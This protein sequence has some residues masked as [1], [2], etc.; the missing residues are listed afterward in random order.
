MYEAMLMEAENEDEG[1]PWR[2][3]EVQGAYHNQT[4]TLARLPD[5]LLVKTML[6]LDLDDILRLR[7]TSRDFMR[8]FSEVPE[9]RSYQVEDKLHPKRSAARVW[10]TPISSFPN[11]AATLFG[12]KLCRSCS[13]KRQGDYFGYRL[14]ESMPWFYCSGCKSRHRAMHFS[15]LQRQHKTDSDRICIGRECRLVICSHL[16]FSWDQVSV[17]ARSQKEP[18][19]FICN[20]RSHCKDTRCVSKRCR[21]DARPKVTLSCDS[22]GNICLKITRSWHLSFISPAAATKMKA[23]SFA[24]EIF[25]SQ[26]AENVLVEDLI[27]SHR[28]K[29]ALPMKAF[30][31]NICSCLDWETEDLEKIR[32]P[33]ARDFKWALT[34]NSYRPWRE[35]CQMPDGY[36]GGRYNCFGNRCLGMRHGFTLDFAGKTASIDF[37]RCMG[38]DTKLILEEVMTC[39][40]TSPCDPGWADLVDV[41]SCFLG[42][43]EE[44]RGI[45][46]CGGVCAVRALR[47]NNHSLKDVEF[48]QS[49]SIS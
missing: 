36:L 5:K 6:L 47:W 12:G 16:S 44:M 30:D 14:V 46:W 23:G 13:A 22:E 29:A 4:T 45:S 48:R 42:L 3:N 38:D 37:L 26:L 43:D 35:H 33:L 41:N 32:R 18:I 21:K 20:D 25:K 1:E 11:Q 34:P 2:M 8:L 39:S 28:F 9:F 24:D 49:K 19:H 27:P 31:P 40:A 17:W 7:H 15:A 10:A